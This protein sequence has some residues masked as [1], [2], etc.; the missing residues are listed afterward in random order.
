MPQSNAFKFA[1]NILTNGGYDAA[2]LVGAADD[3]VLLATTTASSSAS[4]SFDGYFS[5]T[6]TNYEVIISDVRPATANTTLMCRFR[7]S[8]ADVTASNYSSSGRRTHQVQG[9]ADVNDGRFAGNASQIDI[10]T[11]SQPASASRTTGSKIIIYNPLSTT[12]FKKVNFQ[13][14]GASDDAGGTNGI[15]NVNQYSQLTDNTNA[16][17]GISFYYASG[18]ISEGIFKLYGIK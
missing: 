10:L 18:N 9:G 5:S 2:D 13:T 1:N 6:Y 17:S 3:Y 8:N 12:S 14:V 15:W 4:V 16:L 11:N 7:R